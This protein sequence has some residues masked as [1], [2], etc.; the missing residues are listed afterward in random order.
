M[1][2]SAL[3]HISDLECGEGNRA[4]TMSYSDGYSACADMLLED[5]EQ[6]LKD[7]EVQHGRIGLVVTGDVASRGA[8]DEYDKALSTLRRVTSRLHIPREYLAI[9]PGNH[10]VSWADCERAFLQKYPGERDTTKARNLVEK[11]AHFQKFFEEATGLK[12]NGPGSVVSFPEFLQLGVALVGFDTTVPCTFR[13]EDNQGIL[14]KE[15]V[16]EGAGLLTQL[17][18]KQPEAFRIAALHHCLNP[19]ADENEKK[20]E[21]SFLR[22][23]KDAR[24][25]LAKAGFTVVVCG[26]E[27]HQR[28]LADLRT[29]QQ[30]FATGSYG[31]RIEGLLERY[32]GD[33]PAVTNRYQI[34][35]FGSDGPG[36]C[37]LRRLRFAGTLDSNWISDDEEGPASIPVYRTLLAFE[38]DRAIP[39][40]GNPIRFAW[41]PGWKVVSVVL[42]TSHEIL[43]GL[44]SVTYKL[45]NVAVTRRNPQESFRAELEVCDPAG[46]S[47]ETELQFKNGRMKSLERV[48]LPSEDPIWSVSA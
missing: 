40:I 39:V 31:L 38:N 34:F 6:V 47:L 16:D 25:F 36:K 45:G 2:E 33:P 9:V 3:V 19:F 1:F 10:D 18:D 41:R 27:H 24:G 46:T 11:I 42:N 17:T 15:T 48:S 28:A 37:V 21:R 13:R 35:F 12:F 43:S 14:L 30:V 5:V 8:A 23:A 29:G 22:N 26:H 7:Y 32:G 20:E 4:E 44:E